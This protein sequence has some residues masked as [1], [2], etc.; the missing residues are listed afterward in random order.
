MSADA[1]NSILDR[2]RADLLAGRA[3]RIIDIPRDQRPAAI[4]AIAVLR[5]ELPV[6]MSWR[7]Y[8]E[9]N[10]NETRMRAR[11]YWISPEHVR[12]L[13]GGVQ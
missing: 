4:S 5:D 11:C 7:T 9:S 13:I 2:L 10:L 1:F 12:E 8:C 6:K 3:V